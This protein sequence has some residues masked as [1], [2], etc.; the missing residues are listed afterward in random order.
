[1]AKNGQRPAP[2]PLLQLREQ[3]FED[4]LRLSK[5]RLSKA[6]ASAG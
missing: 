4:F 3:T 2:T 5:G 6:R 1:M